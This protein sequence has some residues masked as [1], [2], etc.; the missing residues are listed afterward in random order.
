MMIAQTKPAMSKSE[1]SV[2]AES[3]T[4]RQAR[5]IGSYEAP[6]QRKVRDL[7]SQ[8]PAV[9][10]LAESFPALLFAL[11][12][13]YATAEQRRDALE[14]VNA[15]GNLRQAAD[16]LALPIWLRK[17]PA[18][19]FAAPLATFPLDA[20]FSLR[21]ASLVPVDAQ[22]SADWLTWVSEALVGGGPEYAL[23][24]ARY[25]HAVGRHLSA[26]NR[27]LMAAWSWFSQ[28]PEC[29]ASQLLRRRWAPDLAPRRARDEFQVW[30]DRLALSDWL[31][32][33]RLDP[34]L[35]GGD[36][37]GYSFEPLVKVADFIA[38]GSALDNCLDQFAQHLRRGTTMVAAVR[39]AGRVVA[40]VEIGLNETEMTMPR[41]VQLRGPKNRRVSPEIWQAAFL[42]MGSQPVEPFANGRLTPAASDRAKARRDLWRDYFA[43]L[44]RTVEPKCVIADLKRNIRKSVSTGTMGVRGS[45]AVSSHRARRHVVPSMIVPIRVARAG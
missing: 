17:L 11:A 25:G 16:A 1:F 34:W 24:M 28:H 3:A 27:R 12:T 42:W 40:C 18:S 22:G 14:V 37:Q 36:A 23:W 39:K 19:A 43:Q 38:I 10:D 29:A 7:A 44:E 4:V 26:S 45:G 32:S 31:G 41:I 35:A 13:G 2:G 21:M 5:R 8:S 9:E 20:E 30:R 6:F 15:G 33:G